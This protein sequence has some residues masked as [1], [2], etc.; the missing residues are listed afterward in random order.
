MLVNFLAEDDE[1][2]DGDAGIAQ[3]AKLA[4]ERGI[5]EALA[6]DE[7]AV[8]AVVADDIG[9][10]VHFPQHRMAR[11]GLVAET[12]DDAYEVEVLQADVGEDVRF[13]LIEGAGDDVGDA[14]AGGL[15]CVEEIGV[16]GE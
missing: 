4:A 2:H 14:L 12:G 6:G 7:H 1:G 16:V 5:V 8:Y 10:V 13:A 3:F 9:E 15:E 11:S